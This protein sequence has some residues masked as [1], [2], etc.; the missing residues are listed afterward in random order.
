MASLTSMPGVMPK[1]SGAPEAKDTLGL[2]AATSVTIKEIAS[3]LITL[4][5]IPG[6]ASP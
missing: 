4:F 2:T 1:R 6:P 3:L 5:R